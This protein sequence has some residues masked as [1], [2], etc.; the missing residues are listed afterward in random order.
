MSLDEYFKD[1]KSTRGWD[2]D[3]EQDPKFNTD[4]NLGRRIT[5]VG[6]AK[7][8]LYRHN[9]RVD[10][11]N[12]IGKDPKMS[13]YGQNH[14]NND[15]P[16]YLPQDEITHEIF[17]GSTGTGKGVLLG[18]KALEAIMNRT[19]LIV[20]DPKQDAF[21][22]QICLEELTKQGRPD[23]LQVVSWPSNFGYTAINQD[24]TSIEVANKIAEALD[25]A[26]TGDAGTDYYRRNGRVALKKVLNLFF[27]GS[28]GLIVRKDFNQILNAIINLKM[29]IE[30][31]DRYE[32]EF[33][34]AKP[35]MA[36]LEECE[37][38]Y[39][40]PEKLKAIYFD[41]TFDA[42]LDGLTKS[43]AELAE[44]GNIFK[45]YTLDGALYEGK[46][47]YIKADMLDIASLK[48]LKMLIN[49]AIIKSR[50]KKANTLVIADEVSFYAT[51][52]LSGALATVRSMGLKFILALQDLAQMEDGIREA[53]LSNCNVKMFYKISDEKT[54]KYVEYINGEEATTS[55][56]QTGAAQSIR[57]DSE[58]LWNAT[59]L[60]AIPRAAVALMMSEYMNTGILI[61]TNF[62]AVAQQFDWSKYELASKEAEVSE[63]VKLQSPEEIKA[64][65]DRYK[66]M[67][68][69]EVE[70][71]NTSLSALVFGSSSL[72][73]F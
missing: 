35:N 55:W 47:L 26:E 65:L 17:V 20:I 16:F 64:K 12:Y 59:R 2:Y 50:K 14:M 3:P 54:M 56:T 57:Q 21:L 24:D 58:F 4:S 52:T 69:K 68:E 36:I 70:I 15:E 34:K 66:V 37:K 62:I 41:D 46:V 48:M 49:D 33:A 29:D 22:P 1:T 73:D 13:Y 25:L 45:K 61:K 40:N 5:S 67:V 9:P 7:S 32:K 71:P 19:G 18:N 51:K 11:R 42:S 28:L 8:E 23:D 30:K 53:I 72:G 6:V 10:P 31:A 39:F 44:A 60:R 27:D 63:E 43:I 38:R